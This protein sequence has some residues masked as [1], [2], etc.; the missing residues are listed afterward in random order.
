MR[1]R[2]G[3]VRDIPSISPPPR[4]WACAVAALV[5]LPLF[6]LGPMAT[7]LSP[8]W[9]LAVPY[10]IAAPFLIRHRLRFGRWP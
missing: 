8:Y 1:A 2:F 7:G 3:T 5:L 9:F 4:P 10:A 6:V